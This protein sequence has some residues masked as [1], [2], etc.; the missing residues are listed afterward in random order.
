MSAW[1]QMK[2]IAYPCSVDSIRQSFHNRYKA[3]KECQGL[4]QLIKGNLHIISIF[5]KN[6][7]FQSQL[8][9]K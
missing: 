2:F 4:H 1:F 5:F 8:L 7:P 3:V 9:L 6:R